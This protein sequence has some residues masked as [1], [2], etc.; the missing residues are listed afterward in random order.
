V[1][2]NKFFIFFFL[3][4]FLLKKKI[5]K[6]LKIMFF[7][8]FFPFFF[9]FF[10]FAGIFFFRQHFILLLIALEIMLLSVNLLI[11]LGAIF[12]DHFSAQIYSFFILNI[13][14]SESAIGLAILIIYYRLKGGISVNLLTLLKS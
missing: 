5:K 10:G 7:F 12:F 3:Y 13:A 6:I 14:A 8:Y 11:V 9:F 1:K 2:K 4:I